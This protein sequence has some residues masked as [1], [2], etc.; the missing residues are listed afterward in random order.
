MRENRKNKLITGYDVNKHYWETKVNQALEPVQRYEQGYVL[1]T[2]FPRA[3][4]LHHQSA[5]RQKY[6]TLTLPSVLSQTELLSAL[7][8]IICC[9]PSVICTRTVKHCPPL[10][11]IL[12]LSNHIFFTSFSSWM[13]SCTSGCCGVI[14]YSTQSKDKISIS[15][16]DLKVLSPACCWSICFNI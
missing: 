16:N 12:F 6:K 1:L 15:W 4:K 13:L 7:Y 5:Q 3:L 10:A 8:L 2:L 11:F 9:L 14:V